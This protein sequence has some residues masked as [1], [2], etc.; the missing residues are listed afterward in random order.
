MK[1]VSCAVAALVLMLAAV[2][3]SGAFAGSTAGADRTNGGGHS[4]GH[5]GQAPDSM[6]YTVKPNEKTSDRNEGLPMACSGAI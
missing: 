1:R 5:S 3:S 4:Y 2:A 6:R